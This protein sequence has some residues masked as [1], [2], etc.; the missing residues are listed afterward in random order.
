[1]FNQ[2]VDLLTGFSIYYK[3]HL[4]RAISRS[5]AIRRLRP[6]RGGSVYDLFPLHISILCFCFYVRVEWQQSSRQTDNVCFRV[7]GTENGITPP[8]N[9]PSEKSFGACFPVITITKSSVSKESFSINDF[10]E[11]KLIISKWK[12]M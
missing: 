10:C 4:L 5:F 7:N 3:P 6:L 1:M 12:N 8:S 9:A 11:N 2:T